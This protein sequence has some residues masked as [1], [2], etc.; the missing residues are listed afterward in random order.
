MFLFHSA[1]INDH[2]LN[3]KW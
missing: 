2:S 1:R 3:M